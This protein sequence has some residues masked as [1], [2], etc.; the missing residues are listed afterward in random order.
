MPAHDDSRE[1]T[2]HLGRL[3]S[4]EADIATRIARAREESERLVAGARAAADGLDARIA[5]SLVDET[6]DLRLRLASEHRARLSQLEERAHEQAE[7]LDSLEG[8]RNRELA[9]ELFDHLLATAS[10]SEALR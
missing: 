7:T 8:A 2:G 1:P 5:R 10:P 3:L 6:R 9:D 4:L